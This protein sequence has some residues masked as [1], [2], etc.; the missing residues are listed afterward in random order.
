[1]SHTRTHRPTRLGH[2]LTPLHRHLRVVA[3]P[4]FTDRTARARSPRIRHGVRRRA[5][6]RCRLFHRV[7]GPARSP[8]IHHAGRDRPAPRCARCRPVNRCGRSRHRL[9]PPIGRTGSSTPIVRT[10]GARVRSRRP[11]RR[12]AARHS[13]A[14][15]NQARGHPPPGS[16][17]ADHPK[18]RRPGHRHPDRAHSA[19]RHSHRRPGRCPVPPR[20][21]GPD[22]PA[23]RP[24]VVTRAGPQPR[25]SSLPLHRPAGTVRRR[26]AGVLPSPRP[27]LPPR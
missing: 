25:G 22:A 2:P 5:A 15:L 13:P 14:C 11:S 7:T 1:M 18:H 21:T 26:A 20:T 6:P 12:R 19:G 8:R 17:R 3:V 27:G 4:V 23:D 10:A 16:N 24:S 9:G